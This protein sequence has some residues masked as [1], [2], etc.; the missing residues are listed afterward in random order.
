MPHVSRR[1][2]LSA[3]AAGA[4]SVCL[5]RSF[6]ADGVNMPNVLFIPVDDLRPV[7]GCYGG[8]AH[9]P[10]MDAL[11][12]RGTVFNRAY[13]QQAVCSP[14]RTSLMTGRRPDTTKIYNL[15]DSFR[16]T[17]PDVVTLSQHF[18]QHGYH[19]QS[20]GKIY[21]PGLDDK[22]S[23]SVPNNKPLN[24]KTYSPSVAAQLAKEREEA[25]ARGVKKPVEAVR[26]LPWEATDY[27]DEETPDGIIAT[28][29][30]EALR[31]LKDQ[32]FFLAVGFLKPHLPFIAPR[33]YFDLYPMEQM[34]LAANRIAPK[35]VPA[36]AMHNWGEL[37]QYKG[38]PQKGPLSDQQA[39]ELIRAYYAATSYMDAQLG[40]VLAELERLDLL[41]NTIVCLWGDHGWH[42]GENGLWC[43]HSNFEI[44]TRA[45]LIVSSPGQKSPGAVSNALVEFVDIYP[46]LCELAGLPLPEGLEGTSFVPVMNDP[47]RT[48]KTAAFSQ[49]PRGKIMGYSMRTDR[50]RYTEW[51]DANKHAVAAELYDH[52]DH[53]REEENLASRE[54]RKGL[55][56]ALSR[57][58][59]AGWKAAKPA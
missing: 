47:G 14:S 12:K 31:R 33:K 29:G 25:R 1:Q 32:R 16:D 3:T 20:F 6:A 57:Q 19:A 17:I 37:R 21:H 54:D 28:R 22:R 40:R 2:F 26:G 8:I 39:L 48:W 30:I 36:I 59:R 27:Q 5:G 49:Y 4:L 9:T 13:C 52:S 23:W 42:L 15:E 7:M 44:A 38:M 24:G 56:A 50:Y 45:P 34:K 35:D 46:S 55:V 10:N 11:A 43:K 51:Q 18:K 53:S 58:L 41:R